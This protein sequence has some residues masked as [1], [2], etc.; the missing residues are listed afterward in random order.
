[1]GRTS[2]QPRAACSVGS[3]ERAVHYAQ[4]IVVHRYE[5][6]VRMSSPLSSQPLP[7]GTSARSFAAAVLAA[8]TAGPIA[9]T[10]SEVSVEP[11]AH[12]GGSSE[13]V[14]MDIAILRGKK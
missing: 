12:S 2:V 8:K 6:E 10:D 4:Q 1:M 5:L 3:A 13:E 9:A 11:A 14:H 7:S